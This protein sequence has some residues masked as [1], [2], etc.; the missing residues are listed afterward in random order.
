MKKRVKYE[1]FISEKQHSKYSIWKTLLPTV[2][3]LLARIIFLSKTDQF[4]LK[5]KKKVT[6][7]T[8]VF[9]ASRNSPKHQDLRSQY[10][11]DK[12]KH[13]GE[14]DLLCNTSS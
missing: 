5:K 7:Q 13:R 11:G 4:Y 2:T 14:H 1:R 10:S 6:L 12:V 9:E 8:K 3:E